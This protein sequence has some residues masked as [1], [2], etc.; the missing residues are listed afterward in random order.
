MK[1][2]RNLVVICIIAT[3]LAICGDYL[4]LLV[5]NS[6]RAGHP[7]SMSILTAGG[8]LGCLSL[9][10]AYGFGFSALARIVRPAAKITAEMILYFGIGGAILGPIIHWMTWM[11]I[12]SALNLGTI[13][14]SPPMDAIVEQGGAPLLVWITAG[15]LLLILSILIALSGIRQPRAI[16]LWLAL[17]NPI[18]LNVLISILG[19][20]S[21]VGRSYLVPMASN[22]AHLSFF[23]ALFWC[24]RTGKVQQPENPEAVQTVS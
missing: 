18:I 17:F 14:S 24:L 2:T 15:V 3:V 7:S 13:S 9:P 4:L 6:L 22:L 19:S 12:R 10:L 8:L 23:L 16:P 11:T 5:V 1:D 21:D 20:F